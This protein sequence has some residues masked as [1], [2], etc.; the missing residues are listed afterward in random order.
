MHSKIPVSFDPYYMSELSEIVHGTNGIKALSGHSKVTSNPTYDDQEQSKFNKDK[1]GCTTQLVRGLKPVV[2][3]GRCLGLIAQND[4][5]N[6]EKS[7][8]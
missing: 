6:K 3:L 7:K 1:I 8:R 4:V 2:I 5:L